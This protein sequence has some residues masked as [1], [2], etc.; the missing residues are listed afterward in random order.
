M[1]SVD[2]ESLIEDGKNNSK[3]TCTRCPSKILLPQ[4]GTYVVKEFNLPLMN[5]KAESDGDSFEEIKDYW[6]IN[7]MYH[8]ENIGFSKTVDD[9]KYLICSD[10]EIGPIGW[11]DLK[12]KL[13]Y[14]ALSRVKHVNS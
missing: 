12:T 6:Q 9:R 14:L 8:F 7:D 11:H 2:I 1:R 13:N 5:R 4:V 10:C 3:I